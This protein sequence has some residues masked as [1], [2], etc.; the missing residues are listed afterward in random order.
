MKFITIPCIST[1]RAF[2]IALTISIFFSCVSALTISAIS[3]SYDSSYDDPGRRLDSV[4]CSDGSNGLLN[5]NFESQGSLPSFPRIG[6]AS[7]IAKWNSP[8]CASCWSL[9][10][11]GTS[12]NVLA[13]DHAG[14]GFNI[15]EA[16]MNQLTNGH[17]KA[18]GRIEAAFMQVNSS[19][20]GL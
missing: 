4:A 14:Q 8:N 12:I 18:L 20:C 13:I 5:R 6:G 3:V 16:A 10:Y 19:Q 15:A 9:T 2:L 17:A 7:A 1:A 11:N